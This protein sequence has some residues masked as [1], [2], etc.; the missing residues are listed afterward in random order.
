MTAS[1]A[2]S[3]GQIRREL[4]DALAGQRD[5]TRRLV[6]PLQRGEVHEQFHDFLS[7]IIWDVGH[8][9]NFEEQWLLRHL[10]G[11]PAHDAGLDQLY[12]AFVNPRQ[13]RGGLAMLQGSEA[14]AYLDDV[15]AEVLALLDDLDIDPDSDP[16]LA[17]G[18]V[19]RM[20]VQHESQHQETILQSLDLRETVSAWEL[21][22]P[23]KLGPPVDDRARV[24]VPAGA[25]P[26]GTDERRWT[27]DNERPAHVVDVSGFDLDVHPVTNRRYAKF[28]AAGGYEQPEHWSP[29]GWQW[30]LDEAVTAPQGWSSD[31]D[32]WRVRRFGRVVPLDPREPVQHISFHEAEAFASWAGGRL[33]TEVEW[34]KAASWDPAT[35]H[36]RRFPWGDATPHD[37]VAHMDLRSFGPLP[38]GS[39]PAGASALGVQDLVG[40]VYQWT[41]S[42]FEGWPG[43]QAFPYPEYSEVF[44]GGDYRVLR[45]ASWAIG[46]PMTRCTYRNW[47]HPQRRQIFAGVRIAWAPEA[48]RTSREDL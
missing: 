28:V 4:R 48:P 44:F 31:G 20:I 19:H 5:L 16:L 37:G 10:D 14:W 32:G 18:Y 47:D 35:G 41:S 15:R 45:G 23:L 12:D 25:F 29:R 6:T 40:D 1:P 2:T 17:D 27:Y 22:A 43:F 8:V 39:R 38:I 46:S 34:E 9:G 26:L 11:R 36:K 3:T 21:G 24:H 7:P 42:P 30:R 33:P 13:S